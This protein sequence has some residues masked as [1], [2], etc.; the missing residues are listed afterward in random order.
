[1]KTVR[2]IVTLFLGLLLSSAWG[3]RS[4]ECIYFI[5]GTIRDLSNSQ[6]LPYANILIKG[7]HVGTTS[8]TAGYF[9]IDSICEKEL[10]LVFSYV[11]YKKLEHHHDYHHPSVEIFLAQSDEMLESIIVEAEHLEGDLESGS[12]EKIDLQAAPVSASESFGEL[13]SLVT[14]VSTVSAGQNIVKPVVHGLHSNRILIVNEG[15]RHEFQNWG[16]DHAPEIDPFLAEEI[17]VVKGASTVRYGPD[18]L[19]G[20]ILIKGPVIELSQPFKGEVDLVGKSNGRST[21]A[22]IKIEKGFKWIGGMAAASIVKQGDLHAP[23][24]QLTNTG[25]NEISYAAGIRL[26]PLPE[27][28]IDL[29]HSHFEEELGILRG[30]VNSNLDDLLIALAVDTPSF[31]MPFSYDIA[32][33]KQKVTHNLYKVMAR[34][35]GPKQS[36][37]IQYGRQDNYRQEFD[38]RKGNDLEIPNIDLNLNTDIIDAEWRHP[39]LGPVTGKIGAQWSMQSN[40]NNEGTNTVPFI[41]N[42]D[43]KRYGIYLIEA[44]EFGQSVL[45]FGLRYDA[46]NASIVGREPNNVIY[47]NELSLKNWSGTIGYKQTLAKGHTFRTNIGTAWRPPNIAELYRFG[48]HL[49]FIEYGL[50]RYEINEKTD[51][52]ST[53][54]V[55][56]EEDRPIKNE[57]GHKWI[58]SYDFDSKKVAGGL[59]AYVNYVENYIYARPAGLT[60]T[61]RGTTPFFIYD[62][63]DALLWGFDAS[64]TVRHTAGLQ[65]V[66][67]A[68]YLW[69]R[70]V[71]SKDYFVGQPPARLRWNLE[72]Q[73]GK[74]AF[75]KDNKFGI[76][77]SYTFKQH[78]KPRILTVD[79]LLNA[80]R[81]DLDLFV[82]D[83]SDFD[84]A[85]PPDG[86]FLTDLHWS[87][88]LHNFTLDFAVRNLLNVRYRSYTDRLRYF[89]DSL[90]RNLILRISYQW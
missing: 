49:S 19:G 84:I 5:E 12:V 61:V 18:A 51:F 68:D 47:R 59:T 74:F 30:S 66:L 1:M 13:A 15:L 4:A 8:D 20:V 69:S 83:A 65:S 22:G 10:D 36:F 67:Q 14:G 64:M 35:I 75:F 37:Q 88:H 45:E 81:T 23:R 9:R 79:E 44:W 34:W 53:R 48:R 90:G 38:V 86:F 55:L 58:A 72:Y 2:A 50:W 78:Q 56:T 25:K 32:P 76:R 63:T 70:Q 6:P 73:P 89:A 54:N 57:I 42:Y 39:A 33:P 71:P 60:R 16:T 11:G 28:D 82:N 24:Y 87:T 80:F 17:A 52:I 27:L 3:Q 46:Q 43:Q 41:P 26:H 62:Q 31:T 77:F 7:S 85:E 29:Q 21:E 40:S